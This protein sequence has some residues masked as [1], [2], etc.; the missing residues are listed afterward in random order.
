MFKKI[1]SLIIITLMLLSII[2]FASAG[3]LSMYYPATN[4]WMDNPNKYKYDP[5][6]VQAVI[7]STKTYGNCN[8][9]GSMKFGDPIPS[10]LIIYYGNFICSHPYND[11]SYIHIGDKK[12][13][14]P[15]TSLHYQLCNNKT[16]LYLLLVDGTLSAF[17]YSLL[18]LNNYDGV[19]DVNVMYWDRG[20]HRCPHIEVFYKGKFYDGKNGDDITI[21]D[22]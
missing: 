22:P 8:D 9:R 3:Q 10:D 15:G 6:P 4:N 18:R 7:V 21:N 13:F 12:T 19:S 1:L 20:A 14:L 16:I 11:G 2:G 5:E 17:Q